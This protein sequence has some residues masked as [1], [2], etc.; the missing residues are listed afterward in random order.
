MLCFLLLA[1]DTDVAL[2]HLISLFVAPEH[3]TVDIKQV[4]PSWTLS[5]GPG[6][7]GAPIALSLSVYNEGGL[8]EVDE[9]EGRACHVIRLLRTGLKPSKMVGKLC[10]LC[11]SHIERVLHKAVYKSSAGCGPRTGCGPRAGCGPRDL[12]VMTKLSGATSSALLD[13]EGSSSIEHMPTLFLVASLCEHM[14]ME[15]VEQVDLHQILEILLQIVT[16]YADFVGSDSTRT[17]GLLLVQPDLD[18]LPGSTI[19]L[20]IAI[21]LLSSVAGGARKVRRKAV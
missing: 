4:D 8:E 12:S 20:S 19:P 16:A 13:V 15:V 17:Q 14:T 9:M 7:P 1:V 21:G 10:L 3:R 18:S 6:P 5:P 2:E 11:L